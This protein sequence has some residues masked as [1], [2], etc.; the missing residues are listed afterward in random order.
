[1]ITIKVNNRLQEILKVKR[2]QEIAIDTQLR[3]ST[4]S[5]RSALASATPVDTGEASQGWSVIKTGFGYS[6]VNNVEH[7]NALNQ[8]TSKQAPR[9]FVERT[10]LRFGK[11][12]GIIVVNT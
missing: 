8:G 10:A 12:I 11:P 5:L 2:A 4:L 6:V 9:L 3:L 1:M 7:I